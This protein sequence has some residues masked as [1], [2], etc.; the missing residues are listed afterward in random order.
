MCD[1]L[2][3]IFYSFWTFVGTILLLNVTLCGI[4]GIT[5]AIKR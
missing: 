3:I 5:I 2:N 1:A 4:L